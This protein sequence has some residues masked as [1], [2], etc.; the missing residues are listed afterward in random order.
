[1]SKSLL[2][3]RKE[4]T[5]IEDQVTAAAGMSL[6]CTVPSQLQPFPL[7]GRESYA[8]WA[9]SSDLRRDFWASI[10]PETDIRAKVQYTWFLSVTFRDVPQL[11]R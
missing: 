10:S 4:E 1:M 2:Y 8:L 9:S 5:E 7:F 3:G 6:G 11:L